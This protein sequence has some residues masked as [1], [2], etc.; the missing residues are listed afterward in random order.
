LTQLEYP[1][2]QHKSGVYSKIHFHKVHKSLGTKIS[3]EINFPD[4]SRCKVAGK[5]KPDEELIVFEN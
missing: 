4:K 1:A 3:T 5:F 2:F